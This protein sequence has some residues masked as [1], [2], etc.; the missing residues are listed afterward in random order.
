MGY[1]QIAAGRAEECAE[2]DVISSLLE[3]YRERGDRWAIERIFS[4][5]DKILGSLARRYARSTGEPYE[6]LLQVGYVGLMKATNN[7]NAR[8]QTKFSSYAYSMIEGEIKHHL[9]DA[10][11]VK[12]PRWAR[13]LYSKVSQAT[14]RLTTELSRPPRE[15]EIAEDL[16]ITPEGLAELRKLFEDT[17]VYSLEGNEIE[18]SAI[19]SLHHESFTLPIEDQIQLERALESLSDLQ[20]K[21]IYLFFYKD[22]RQTEIGRRL[23]LSQRKT[24]RIVASALKGLKDSKVMEGPEGRHG[25]SLE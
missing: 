18:V 19:K 12:R 9:R 22:L 6:D 5:N 8:P 3:T 15:Q 25:W 20:R 23:G 13:S 1:A 11:L 4:L 7:Y 14:T 10:G 2:D 16:N 21:V 17:E 24:S